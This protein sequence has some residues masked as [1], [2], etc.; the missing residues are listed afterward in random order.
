MRFQLFTRDGRCRLVKWTETLLIVVGMPWVAAAQDPQ[1]ADVAPPA[2]SASADQIVADTADA[3]SLWL[4]S[5]PK[6]I[7]QG[8]EL[9]RKLFGDGS[10]GPKK[11]GFYPQ[12]SNMVTGAGFVSLGP[13]YRHNLYGG[14]AFFD[15]SGA[16]SWHLYKMAQARFEFPKLAGDHLTIGGQTMWQDETQINYFGVGGNP[17]TDDRAQYR[18]Q[19]TDFIGYAALRPAEWLSLGAEIGWLKSPRVMEAAGT[20]KLD[21]PDARVAFPNDPGMREA[22]QPDFTHAEL[23]V[24]ADTLDSRNHPTAGGLYRAAVVRYVDDTRD[25]YSFDQF[26]AEAIQMVRLRDRRFIL[27]FHGWT[28]FSDVADGKAVPFYLMPSLGGHNTLRAYHNFQ[29]H[30]QNLIV[31][32]VELRIALLLHVDLAAFYDAGNVAARYTDLNFDRRSIGAGLRLHTRG[33]TFARM[34]VAHGS[35]G[36]KIVV[37]TSEP[38]KLPRVT[39][40]LPGVPFMP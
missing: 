26:E 33:A 3:R 7:P 39:R 18:L 9:G 30:D 23:S 13:G 22:V 17:V 40:R 36:W 21:D 35:E 25:V 5:E 4:F 32:N 29:F 38:F 8:L 2:P 20:F 27:A 10:G 6:F 1:A 24:T 31:A 16:V 11:T 37:R 28:M 12:F 15:T 14:K 34:D 19:S